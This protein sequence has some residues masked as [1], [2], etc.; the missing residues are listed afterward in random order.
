[1]TDHPNT[2]MTTTP[3]VNTDRA[4]DVTAREEDAYTL[5]V[6]A[7]LWG[8]PMACYARASEAGVRVGASHVNAFRRI[9]KLKTAADRDVVTPT[10]VTIDAYGCLDLRDEPV[11]VHVPT[12]TEPRWYIVQFGDTFDEVATN[13]GGIK[14]PRPGAYAVCGPRFDGKLPGEITAIH[15]RTTQC[16]CTVRVFVDG[17]ADLPNAVEVQNG[18]HLMPL[19][20]LPARKARLPLARGGA[21]AGARRRGAAGVAAPR[22]HRPGD[23]LVP[24][25]LRRHR[26]PAGHV[27]SPHRPQRRPRLRLRIAARGHH[28]RARARRRDGRTHHRRALG[29]PRRDHQRLALQHCK[30]A[31]RVRRRAPRGASQGCPS[32]RNS[33]T[34]FCTRPATLTPTVS[35]CT[36]ATTTS[37]TS[38]PA[39]IRPCPCSGTCRCSAKT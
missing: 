22:P 36:G 9:P 13:I 15:L 38:R 29:R 5:G 16:I 2:A 10:N 27:V 18:F 11:V 33:P 19:S 20:A 21:A 32:G 37:F 25:D 26:R 28:P 23:A 7:V 35:R 31:R 8:Y 30:R 1:M 12:L 34:R 6:Q 39:S 14:G 3:S 17:E 24:A 4:T